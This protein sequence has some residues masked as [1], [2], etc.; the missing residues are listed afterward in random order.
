ML[1]CQ[2]LQVPLLSLS[3]CLCLC[4]C[5]CVTSTS[6]PPRQDAK[7]HY[8][9]GASALAENN[10]TTALQEFQ[11]AEKYDSSDPETQSGLSQAY[12]RKGA[13]DLAEKHLKNAIELSDGVPKY[14]NNLGALYLAMERNDDA[15]AAFRKAAESLLF[16]TPEMAW[17]GMGYAYFNK[18]DYVAAERYYKK[19]REMNP[20]Y[21]QASFRLGELY[22]GQDRSVEALAAFERA[23]ELA[24]RS[25]E[26]NYWF[27][28]AS[29]KTRDNAK[30]RRA[31]QETIKLAP[32]SELAR[33]SRNY[34]KVLQ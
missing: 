26:Y 1:K 4:L 19:A 34:L 23:V 17:A 13:Y 11:L 21:A 29:M 10:P 25:A 16:A 32:D 28:L 14:Y 22:Y 5:A 3:L 30:A 12:Q 18:H 15:I 33:L 31:F 24:P 8:L 7:A 27:G 9:A 6:G 20:R 2:I